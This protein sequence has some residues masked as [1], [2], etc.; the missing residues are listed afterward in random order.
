MLLYV[1]Y[2]YTRGLTGKYL[3]F[4]RKEN[5]INFITCKDFVQFLQ[6]N[7]DLMHEDYQT[8]SESV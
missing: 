2:R 3:I 5:E 1:E 8:A 7:L 6:M 4:R